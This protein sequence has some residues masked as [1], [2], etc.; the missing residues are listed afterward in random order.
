MLAGVPIL[1][2]RSSDL[3]LFLTTEWQ[4]EGPL[5]FM[6]YS[7]DGVSWKSVDLPPPVRKAPGDDCCYAASIRSLC[8]AD[9][10]LVFIAYDESNEFR[11]SVWSTST[12]RL[13]PANITWS[14][15]SNLPNDARCDEVRPGDFM[16]RSLRTKTS[17]GAIFDVSTDWAVRIPGPTR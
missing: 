13:F 3:G 11:E 6:Y 2:Q 5:N 9:S 14:R 16:P 4:A 10:G 7:A 15:Q 8:V 1:F 12:D 17:D